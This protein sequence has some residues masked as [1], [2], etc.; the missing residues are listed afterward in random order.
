MRPEHY[1]GKLYMPRSI[2]HKSLLLMLSQI[3][4]ISST[5]AFAEASQIRTQKD[6]S[7]KDIQVP[8]KSAIK[9]RESAVTKETSSLVMIDAF[10]DLNWWEHFQDPILNRYIQE[11]LKTNQDLNLAGLKIQESKALARQQLGVELPQV[12]FA[13]SF[14]RQKNSKNLT[15]PNQQILSAAGPRL[16]APGA[17][18]NIYNA[19]LKVNYEADIWG[20][21]WLKIKS[22]RK[23]EEASALDRRNSM[24][25]VASEVATA[26]FNFAKTD[27][28]IDL[29]KQLVTNR[30]TT[31]DLTRIRYEGGLIDYTQ[32]DQAENDLLTQEN[33]LLA[34]QKARSTFISQ[35]AVLTGKSPVNGDSL[36]HTNFTHLK[37][38]DTVPVGVPST[39]LDRRPDILAAFA[40]L[41]SA[42]I[43][44]QEAKRELLPS[45]T[46]TG[47]FGY[48]STHFNNLLDWQS[49][50]ASLAAGLTQ[51]L[52]T[53]GQKKAEIKIRQIQ[54]KEQME[55]Y[56]KTVLTAF[57]EVEDSLATMKSDFVQQ[58]NNTQAESLMEEQTNIRNE[59]L[60][61]GLISTIDYNQ[62][63]QS[64]LQSQ[65]KSADSKNALFI[66]CIS[67]Y[68]S[69][70][71]G[72]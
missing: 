7:D 11:A 16:F 48:A 54:V 28:L 21:N 38:P 55:T 5:I 15:V 22:A 33:Q 10:P 57:E 32:V 47:Q 37:A 53:G 25:Q 2:L 1:L 36:T 71:G 14:T 51:D 23:L 62:A 19:P 60:T 42:G 8:F 46:L 20:K 31:A 58:R 27:Y 9:W 43:N 17:T 64:W 69:L 49:H 12:S 34:Y 18:T 45:I 44:V 4:I 61:Q 24:L 72:F 70:G 52:Y 40:R 6:T 3:V 65:Q 59:Q 66:D 13:P 56:Q 50:L 68:K 39:L 67:I 41:E 35:L 30:Q 26:Y 29:Q 63:Q